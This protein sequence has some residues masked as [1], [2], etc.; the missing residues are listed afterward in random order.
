VNVPWNVPWSAFG[1][2][3]WTALRTG[4]AIGDEGEG[5][6]PRSGPPAAVFTITCTYTPIPRRGKDRTDADNIRRHYNITHA[7]EIR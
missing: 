1:L 7:L 5:P 6:G 2:G 4:R 3:L